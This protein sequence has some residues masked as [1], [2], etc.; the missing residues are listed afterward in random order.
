MP[1]YAN[2]I[3]RLHGYDKDAFTYVPIAI[4]GAGESGVAMGCRLKQ[5]LGFDQ[6][7]IFERQAGIGGTWWINRYPGVA[8]DVPA[9]FYSFSFC[10]N[11]AWTALYPSGP[12]IVKYIH[13]VCSK[14]QIH[15]KIQCDTNVEGCKWLEDEQIWEV[16][17]QHM[18]PGT[19]DLSVRDRKKKIDSEGVNRVFLKK[20]IVRAKIVVSAVG[21]LVEPNA[22]PK[23]P[24]AET[25]QGEVFHS[26]RWKEDI[27]LNDKS[28]I[29]LGTGCSA[30]QIVPELTEPKYNAKRVTQLMRTPPWVVPKIRDPTYEKWSPILQTKVP[31]LAWTLR[32]YMFL[33]GEYDFRL[34]G[35]SEYCAKER[36]HYE[37]KLLKY[38]RKHVPKQYQEMLIPNYS[39][40][41]KRRIFDATWFPS[42][43]SSR[44]ELTTKPL[45]EVRPRSIV[46]GPGQSHPA[47]NADEAPEQREIA[48]DIIIQANGFETTR[49][50]HP[51]RVTG[52]RGKDLVEE[53]E[54]RGGPQ[55][56]QG[57]AMDGFPNFFMIFGPN[58]ATGHSSVILASENMV[59]YSLSFIKLILNGDV[60]TVDVKCEAEMAYT[61]DVQRALKR[62]VFN[63]G[64]CQSW[65]FNGD[66]NSTVFP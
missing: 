7:R 55:A 15:D 42:L 46:V 2:S 26:A 18:V 48:A 60:R 62:S 38:L 63:S 49:W 20:E 41:C 22:F 66:W 6:F 33:Q 28:V 14:F 58:T 1:Q 47:F 17:L 4:I 44:I 10:P 43:N 65:Y 64:G 8:C 9:L 40:G 54:A 16:S 56:Y 25:F 36:V 61:A 52:Q 29:V 13:D 23:I 53:M 39:V 32:K 34:F 45:T 21:G 5:K 24:G 59:E 12:E 19:G 31:G 27:D 30:A 35:M 37:K 57:T 3:A 50:L 11:Y 51:L